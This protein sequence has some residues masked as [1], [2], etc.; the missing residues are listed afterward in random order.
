MLV[1]LLKYLLVDLIF[2]SAGHWTKFGVAGSSKM[3]CPSNSKGKVY[4]FNTKQ[5][6]FDQI[7]K[8]NLYKP[9]ANLKKAL[10]E[11]I[12][13]RKLF[14]FYCGILSVVYCDKLLQLLS[15][16]LTV[17][18]PASMKAAP[19]TGFMQFCTGREFNS[20]RSQRCFFFF[21]F[22]WNSFFFL[23]IIGSGLLRKVVCISNALELFSVPPNLH[24]FPL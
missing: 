1:L 4:A 14:Y 12:I 8:S 10:K 19:I 15:V 18:L 16:Q 6:N 11:N 5:A 9:N 23:I 13:K 22:P 7:L 17:I 24:V 21:F 3:P 20:T 2:Y